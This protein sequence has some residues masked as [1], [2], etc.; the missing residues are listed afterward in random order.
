MLRPHAA[1]IAAALLTTA[2]LMA[3]GAPAAPAPTAA[4]IEPTAAPAPTVAAEPTA[5]P[6]AEAPAGELVIYTSRAETLF[7]PVIAAFNAAYPDVKITLLTGGNN[8]LAAKILEERA[9]PIGDVFI[10]SD[11]LSMEALAA[12]GVFIPNDSPAVQSVPLA[13]RA[14]DG[15]WV[16]LTLRSRVIMYNTDLVKPE[17]LPT[18]IFDLTDPK[19]R[20]QIGA[21]NSTNG[22]M[23]ANLVA[24]RNV[25]GEEKANEF[26][27]G[28]IANETQFFGGHTDVRKAV[29]A[30]ELKLG[31]VNHYYYHL[32]KAEGAPV[33][34]I[35][36]DQGEGQLGLV[37]NSTN[38]GI[39]KGSQHEALAKLFVDFM[40]SP[41]GQKIFAEGNFEH[42]IVP[43]V[44]LAEGVEPLGNFKLS[45]V[46]L[47]TMWDE[48]EP[49]KQLAQAAGLP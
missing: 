6:S 18:S 34:I 49:T 29:G 9:N 3:C 38:A 13:Y 47:K 7:N 26:I 42:P 43:G 48:L 35:Y 4:P 16:S 20:G 2:L 17:E 10:N 37:V 1:K 24:I 19:W 41:E 44:Q 45:N 15:N 22:A 5:A 28:L 21:A 14:E 31:F 46:T 36:P 33:G 25:F 11:T 27:S 23:M 40:L 30:G 32:S 8:D 39:I 12:E